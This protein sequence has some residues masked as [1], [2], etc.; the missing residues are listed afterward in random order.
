MPAT[1]W[2]TKAIEMLVQVPVDASALDDP[3][4]DELDRLSDIEIENNI[5]NIRTLDTGLGGWQGDDVLITELDPATGDEMDNPGADR[6]PVHYRRT[7]H[8][9][10]PSDRVPPRGRRKPDGK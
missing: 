8:G 7:K 9:L 3:S 4:A 2:V 10:V 6:F 1:H 5:T